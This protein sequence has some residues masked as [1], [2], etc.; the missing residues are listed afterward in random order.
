MGELLFDK[1]IQ[2]ILDNKALGHLFVRRGRI[3]SISLLRSVSSIFTVCQRVEKYVILRCSTVFTKLTNWE[4]ARRRLK[5][6]YG[7]EL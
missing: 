4:L 5:H 2:H 7:E 3:L 1:R 6:P